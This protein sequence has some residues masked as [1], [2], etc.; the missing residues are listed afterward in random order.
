VA[1]VLRGAV[2][3][4][5]KKRQMTYKLLPGRASFMVNAASGIVLYEPEQ[6]RDTKVV[7][8]D[9]S[10][11]FLRANHKVAAAS[12]RWIGVMT[13]SVSQSTVEFA[14]ENV[15]E[16]GRALQKTFQDQRNE[17]RAMKKALSMSLM[18]EENENEEERELL[19]RAVSL[20]VLDNQE[21]MEEV[22]KMQ[23]LIRQSELEFQLDNDPEANLARALDLSRKECSEEDD[24][25]LNAL[26]L[27]MLD[28]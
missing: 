25:L 17:D 12:D 5:L 28:F 13:K 8:T 19:R 7:L 10:E 9:D 26:E 27:S 4:L 6:P 16:N 14:N 23:E 3:E 1:A 18:T 15:M 20:S 11:S 22:K 21:E 24:D 2:E